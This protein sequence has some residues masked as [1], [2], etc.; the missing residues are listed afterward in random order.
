MSTA[1]DIYDNQVDQ[2]VAS[3]IISKDQAKTKKKSPFVKFLLWVVGFAP[4]ITA[5]TA[6]CYTMLYFVGTDPLDLI[7]NSTIKLIMNLIILFSAIVTMLLSFFMNIVIY[8]VSG[9]ITIA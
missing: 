5:G 6:I 3:G 1:T 9:L 2:S 7:Q 8:M 4:V